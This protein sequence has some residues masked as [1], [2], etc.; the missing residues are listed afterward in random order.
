MYRM[1]SKK[2]ELILDVLNSIT[3]IIPL[4]MEWASGPKQFHRNHFTTSMPKEDWNK[5]MEP[6]RQRRTIKRLQNKKLLEARTAGHKMILVLHMDAMAVALKERIRKTKKKLPKGTYC[7]VLF[8]FPVGA[9]K[10]AASWRRFIY[11]A[12]F[13]REQ[14]SAWK[15][16]RDVGSMMVALVH[17]MNVK[18]WI[19]VYECTE[20]ICSISNK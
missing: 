14:L 4:A 15:T 16:D 5:M 9:S 8:D 10:A 11:S 17:I 19:N 3:S 20:P 12:N 18:R 13:R 6:V 7:L 1:V 2:G